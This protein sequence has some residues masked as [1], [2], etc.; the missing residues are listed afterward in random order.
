MTEL[1][2]DD[3]EI[4]DDRLRGELPEGL[5][6]QIKGT[7]NPVSS[8]HWIKKYFFDFKDS[9]TFT[10][11]STYLDNA[12]IDATHDLRQECAQERDWSEL[13]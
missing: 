12:F 2:Q 9:D 1:T 13:E 10:H 7:F 8:S 4:I 3:F 6:Y 5:F 11:H